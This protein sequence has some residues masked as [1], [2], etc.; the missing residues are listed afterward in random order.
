MGQLTFCPHL[1]NGDDDANRTYSWV[2]VRVIFLHG[3]LRPQ[4]NKL[5]IVNVPPKIHGSSKSRLQRRHLTKPLRC[6]RIQGWTAS[7][8]SQGLLLLPSLFSA[9]PGFSQHLQSTILSPAAR[10]FAQAF[11]YIV[12]VRLL[13]SLPGR[14]LLLLCVL[15]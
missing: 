10:A 5:F 2:V 14:L 11:L 13:P 12:N 15:V 6:S 8:I 4:L 1:Q 7:L 3:T 9:Y